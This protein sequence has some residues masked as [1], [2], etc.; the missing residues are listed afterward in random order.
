MNESDLEK[1]RYPVGKYIEKESISED[2]LK[3]YI[4][5]FEIF[6]FDLRKAIR[7]LDEKH[8][9][10]PY[11]EGGWTVRQVVHHVSDS[12]INGYVRMKLALTEDNPAIKPYYE[13]RWAE[14]QDYKLT[15]TAISLELLD[16]LHKRWAIVMKSLTAQQLKRT[17]FHPET[18]ETVTLENQIGLYSWH[19][20]HHLEH[21]IGLKKRMG[22]ETS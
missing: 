3:E 15:P 19:C 14:L 13:D 10:T 2:T 20:R 11:R 8:M 4:R 7:N 12:H 16:H 9:E 5:V 6:P 1:L 21:I 17:Y 22:W 18:K